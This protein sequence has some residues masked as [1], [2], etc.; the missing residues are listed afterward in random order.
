MIALLTMFAIL[1]AWILAEVAFAEQT[2]YTVPTEITR[3]RTSCSGTLGDWTSLTHANFG[4][5]SGPTQADVVMVGDSIFTSSVA[6]Q[7]AWFSAR[8]KTLAG[9]YWSGRPAKPAVDW[10]LSLST[11]PKILVF[12]NL[13]NNI[14]EPADV[15]PQLVRLK[16][17]ADAEPKTRL[18]VVDAHAAR[19]TTALCDQ[20][21][22]G[23]INTQAYQVSGGA[24][25]VCSWSYGFAQDPNRIGNYLKTDGLHTIPGV[26][27]NYRAAVVGG[28]VY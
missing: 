2:T 17:W 3:K 26:G 24:Y 15:T 9:S 8:G 20:R 11:K 21:N 25:Q 6:E 28:C 27:D 14:F 4:N 18:I 12:A 19:P 7:I 1:P 23:W 16:A 13:T 10:A 5:L 22:S